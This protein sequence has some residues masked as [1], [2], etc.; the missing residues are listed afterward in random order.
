M[1]IKAFETLDCASKVRIHYLLAQPLDSGFLA[2]FE[3]ASLRI[4]AFS[5]IVAG[6]KD[7]FTLEWAGAARATGVIGER[8]IVVTFGKVDLTRP[9]Q[10]I[11]QFEQRLARLA[12]DTVVYH[13]GRDG[14]V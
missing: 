5:K 2:R 10:T 9:V 3:G 1:S 12:Q 13:K 14:I 6:A 7:H 4:E 11:A 8:K